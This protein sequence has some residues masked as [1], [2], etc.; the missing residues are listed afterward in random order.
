MLPPQPLGI[1]TRL[2]LQY[3]L[4]SSAFPSRSVG[5]QQLPH[6]FAGHF[7]T[8]K[9]NFLWVTCNYLERSVSSLC[10][11]IVCPHCVCNVVLVS[12]LCV[13]YRCVFRCCLC[14]TALCVCYACVYAIILSVYPLYVW[15]VFVCFTILFGCFVC[16]LCCEVIVLASNVWC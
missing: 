14:T 4:E 8:V 12:P 6:I 3:K 13:C 9:L 7:V 10:V 11:I 1:H 15:A 16:W 5:R 2:K